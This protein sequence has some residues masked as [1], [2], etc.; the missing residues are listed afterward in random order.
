MSALTRI[1]DFLSIA[2]MQPV[3]TRG[4]YDFEVY[5]SMEQQMAALHKKGPVYKLPSVAQAMGVPSIQRAVTLI[6]NTVGSLPMQA[7]RNGLV[8]DPAPQVVMR[9]NPYRTPRDAYRDM[10]YQMATRGETVLWIA[11][12]DDDGTAAA[13]MLVPLA[14]LNVE[15]NT[16]NRLRP[17]YTW[18]NIKSTRYSPAHPEGQFVHITYLQEPGALRGMGPLQMANAATSVAV[19][20]QEWAARFYAQGGRPTTELHTEMDLT[21]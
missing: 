9:P 8:M 13:L 19:E 7:F 17:I 6:S 15:E 20:A 5:P 3:Q 18:G 1:A 2:P 10:A 21:G 4:A 16:R 11:K 12:R 14:E